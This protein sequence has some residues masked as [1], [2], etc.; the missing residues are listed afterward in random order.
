MDLSQLKSKT[1]RKNRKR[2]G[3]GGKRGTYSG[4]GMKGQKSRAGAGVKPGFRGG[5]SRLWQLFPKQRGASKKPGGSNP[6]PKHRYFQLRHTKPGVLNLGFFNQFDVD[7][8]TPGLLKEKGLI[9]KIANG[10]KILGGG[11]LKKK[12]Q[13]EGFQFSKS[14]KNKVLKAGG[15]IK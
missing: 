4:K 2:V 9:D 7:V 11:E 12:M 1:L 8:V 6:H 13:F 10:V 14:A 15:T 3:R 5:D